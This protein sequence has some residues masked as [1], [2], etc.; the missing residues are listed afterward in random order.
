[1]RWI[2]LIFALLVAIVVGVFLAG[3]MLPLKHSV[4][5]SLTLHQKPEAV[6]QAVTDHQHDPQWRSDV[7][8]VTRLDDR[9]GHPLWEEK[10]KNG[11]AMRIETTASE[12]PRRLVRKIVDQTMF[13]G[14]WTYEVTP[15]ADG[16]STTVR[17]TEDGEVYNP[18]FRFIARFVMGHA[19]TLEKYLKSLAEK[20]GET[21]TPQP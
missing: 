9:N 12:P 17:I 2:A 4:S 20:F 13:G 16:N 8:N 7:A 14:V 1:M 18:A 10:Y 3:A 19:T 6:W 11:D 15:S 21:A 5:R